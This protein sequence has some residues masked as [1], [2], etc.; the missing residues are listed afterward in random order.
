MIFIYRP[1]LV[2]F[3]KADEKFPHSHAESNLTLTL[4]G[5]MKNFFTGFFLLQLY[6]KLVGITF[7]HKHTKKY[8]AALYAVQF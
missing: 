5:T 3:C 1:F 2:K 8:V 7:I 6:L 4:P